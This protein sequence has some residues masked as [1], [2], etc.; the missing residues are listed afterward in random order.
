MLLRAR[1]RGGLCLGLLGALC[2]WPSMWEIR[3]LIET[4][5]REE[6]DRISDQL[7]NVPCPANSSVASSLRS[8]CDRPGR[9][10]PS[11]TTARRPGTVVPDARPLGAHPLGRGQL[12]P[13]S[14]PGGAAVPAVCA[15]GVGWFRPDQLR[16]SGRAVRSR[17]RRK[18][19]TR[20][21]SSR[22]SRSRRSGALS[23]AT[24]LLVGRGC[25]PE[26]RAR[27]QGGI[28]RSSR[29]PSEVESSATRRSIHARLSRCLLTELTQSQYRESVA[30]CDITAEPP[31][32][33]ETFKTTAPGL[34]QAGL[35]TIDLPAAR[36]FMATHAR[37]L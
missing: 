25:S 29:N 7:A 3:L 37:L 9:F 20:P 33:A 28:C 36:G 14:T 23:A 30:V 4:D 8:A 26:S 1:N 6:L 13:L 21:G 22:Q 32:V 18:R 11:A 15:H 10:S 12:T 16:S 27:P 35:M 17:E 34:G 31:S 5:S 2:S 24:A 19:T